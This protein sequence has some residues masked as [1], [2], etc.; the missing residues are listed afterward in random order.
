M[1]AGVGQCTGLHRWSPACTWE[2]GAPFSRWAEALLA[3]ELIRPGLGWPCGPAGSTVV[4]RGTA[5]WGEA[6]E[7]LG[8]VP[9][10]T[11]PSQGEEV[12]EGEAPLWAALLHLWLPHIL[13]HL[14]RLT[15]GANWNLFL[16]R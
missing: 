6:E 1:S 8:V 11:G 3:G 9:A 14:C 7:D 15:A 13:R 12:A 10:L 16:C 5:S 4:P 2:G